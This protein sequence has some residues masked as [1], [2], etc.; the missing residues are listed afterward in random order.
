M[1]ATVGAGREPE[2]SHPTGL[3]PL[4]WL[5]LSGCALGGLVVPAAAAPSPQAVKAQTA[6]AEQPAAPVGSAL[7]GATTP[8]PPA[9]Q[10]ASAPL[11]ANGFL[12]ALRLA[13]RQN[14]ESLLSGA[15]IQE[16][17]S[18]VE[19]AK[20]QWLPSGTVQGFAQTNTLP[21]SFS[22]QQ[23][24]YTF[25]RLK[26]T[27]NTAKENEILATA[28]A[29]RTK[30]DLVE[31]TAIAYA[32][33]LTAKRQLAT[34]ANYLSN[35]EVLRRQISNRLQAQVAA[36]VDLRLVENRLNQ[37]E[38]KGQQIIQDLQNANADLQ[39]LTSSQVSTEDQIPADLLELPARPELEALL[40]T[41]N[42]EI[43]EAERE[44][45]LAESQLALTRT[46]SLPTLSLSVEQLAD[47]ASGI[48]REVN[49]GLSIGTGI[50]GLGIQNAREIAAVRHQ[51]DAAK[52]QKD[53][54]SLQVKRYI[55]R[56]VS[57]YSST[58]I[59]ID[60][61]RDAIKQLTS[62]V[63]SYQNQ[64]TAGFRS[65]LDLLNLY[66]ELNESRLDLTASEGDLSILA[67]QLNARA[68]R[69]DQ[70]AGIEQP[71]GVAPST[72]PATS[73]KTPTP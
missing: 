34:Q 22:V 47:V 57:Q 56:L 23:P 4:A 61:N 64:Y 51:V 16:Q 72:P 70:S 35:L 48:S 25:G 33:V 66:R 17:R 7:P 71:D 1:A 50:N 36:T 46:Q 28:K 67:L 3:K 69:L 68:G 60:A 62:L 41:N 12:A 54:V 21:L 43:L 29:L 58:R 14:P 2:Q 10:P 30:R 5:L 20:A 24:L 11:P 55:E 52:Y 15:R 49:Y 39:A 6:P 19:A 26:Y 65:W 13:V 40:F 9:G 42:V 38:S 53:A 27:I 8:T 59:I 63:S 18:L 45:K 44:I 32:R 73:P 31:N 37:A